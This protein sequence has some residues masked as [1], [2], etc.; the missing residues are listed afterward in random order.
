M[1]TYLNIC[2]EHW[3]T[4]CGSPHLSCRR[5]LFC[6]SGSFSIM[7]N[8]SLF[9]MQQN[10]TFPFYHMFLYCDSPFSTEWRANVGLSTGCLPLRVC[11]L[12]LWC[13]ER[14]QEWMWPTKRLRDTAG[15]RPAEGITTQSARFA[16]THI[17]G[18]ST[19]WN[20]NSQHLT[21]QLVLTASS[22]GQGHRV[23]CH[24]RRD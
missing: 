21:R 7:L 15:R 5:L 3:A 9:M 1:F 18:W 4:C 14:L 12:A 19:G 11:F 8:I 13:Q 23:A 24:R 22:H 6:W 2:V 16:A 20:D 10:A 17:P